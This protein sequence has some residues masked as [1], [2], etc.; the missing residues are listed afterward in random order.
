MGRSRINCVN[1]IFVISHQHIFMCVHAP[2]QADIYIYFDQFNVEK[3]LLIRSN[4][5]CGN[6]NT[7]NSIF[8]G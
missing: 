4:I 6:T 5:Q 8:D 7:Q 3:A 2:D 1:R